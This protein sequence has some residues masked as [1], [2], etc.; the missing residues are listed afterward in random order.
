MLFGNGCKLGTVVLAL[1][2]TLKE[3]NSAVQGKHTHTYTDPKV[4]VCGEK[5]QIVYSVNRRTYIIQAETSA[6]R[7]TSTVGFHLQGT[8]TSICYKRL[9]CKRAQEEV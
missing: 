8:Q 4:C 5:S 3:C 1:V 7:V 2:F 6:P 9:V